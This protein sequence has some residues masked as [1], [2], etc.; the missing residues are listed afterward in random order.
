MSRLF[1]RGLPIVE[2]HLY[3]T[4][5]ISLKN[6]SARRASTLS[7]I[8]KRNISHNQSGINKDARQ[9]V[10]VEIFNSSII[11]HQATRKR[12]LPI[13]KSIVDEDDSY[14]PIFY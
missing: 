7:T 13:C 6:A 10:P 14:S 12:L 2:S 1:L 4:R 11:T 8:H 5:F 3:K 9:T